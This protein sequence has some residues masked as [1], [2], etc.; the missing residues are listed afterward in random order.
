MKITEFA[1]VCFNLLGYAGLMI[2]FLSAFK[3]KNKKVQVQI[4]EYH[5][6]I[7]ELILLTLGGAFVLRDFYKRCRA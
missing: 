4:N 7:P 1:T 3:D 6:A 5:E 2:V